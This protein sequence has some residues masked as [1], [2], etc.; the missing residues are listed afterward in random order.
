MP[1]FDSFLYDSGLYDT[2]TSAG[3]ASPS[4]DML[5][6]EGYSL[7]NNSTIILQN[8]GIK[9]PT[10]EL[11]TG[12]IPRRDGMWISG[13]FFRNAVLEPFGLLRTSSVAELEA[14]IDEINGNLTER[15]GNLDYT[16]LDGTVRRYRATMTAFDALFAE[17]Q[18]FHITACPWKARFECL[19][20]FAEDREYTTTT[21]MI[22]TSPFN[23]DVQNVGTIDAQ[24]VIYLNFDA[25]SGVTAASVKNLTTGEEVEYSGALVAGDILIFDSEQTSVSLNGVVKKFAGSLPSLQKGGNL[26]QLSFIGTSAAIT[27]TLKWKP[28]YL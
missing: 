7:A 23:Q 22:G 9:G 21:V 24:P 1:L 5:V 20:P 10:R 28:R 13:V 14:L 6:F 2:A 4:T 27:A 18:H 26:L 19:T 11:L 12:P 8:P 3:G 16:R 17:R 25:A 15:E